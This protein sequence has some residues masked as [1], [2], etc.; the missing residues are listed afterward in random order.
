APVGLER[1]QSATDMRFIERA[2]PRQLVTNRDI[3]LQIAGGGAN[4]KI[5]YQLAYLNGSNDGRSSEDFADVDVNDDKEYAARIFAQPCADS[6]SF[7]LRGLGLGIAGS[8][9]SQEGNAT[10]TLLP[11]FR[12][13]AQSVFFRY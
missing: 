1:L 13:P 3:G 4:S 11:Q 10:Q 12:T 2:Y 8:W 7:A 5:Q 6:D 9:T